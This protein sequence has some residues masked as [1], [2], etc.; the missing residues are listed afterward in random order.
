MKIRFVRPWGVYRPG[1]VIE[2][3][4]GQ[5]NWMVRQNIAEPVSVEPEKVETA[6]YPKR[7]KR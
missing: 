7:G 4:D 3:P 6:T 2:P 1:Q 5:A